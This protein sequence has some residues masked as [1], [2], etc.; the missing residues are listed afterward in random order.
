M[1]VLFFGVGGGG[2]GLETRGVLI[3]RP[4]EQSSPRVCE[5]T[6]ESDVFNLALLFL[7]PHFRQRLWSCRELEDL[8]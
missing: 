5:D 3:T 2:N 4:G 1:C 6:S 7:P 8:W